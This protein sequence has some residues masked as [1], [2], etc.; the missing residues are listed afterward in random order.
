MKK[1]FFAFALLAALVM[2]ATTFAAEEAAAELKPFDFLLFAKTDL[3]RDLHPTAKPEDATA[4]FDKPAANMLQHTSVARV[5]VF[6]KGWMNKHSMKADIKVMDTDAG[7]MV[8]AE[9]LSDSNA[10]KNLTGAKI[11][12]RWNLLSDL[13]W[14]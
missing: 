8:Y 6:Y 4:E 2:G 3:L 11:A 5:E 10:G 12:G 7:K 1:V 13:G 14:K 9:V